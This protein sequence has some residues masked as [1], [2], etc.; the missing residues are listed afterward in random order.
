VFTY[1]LED[2][3]LPLPHP[4]SG[5]CDTRNR[6]TH[7]FQARFGWLN[8]F[9]AELGNA[10]IIFYLFIKLAFPKC[11]AQQVRGKIGGRPP[12]KL[13]MTHIVQELCES[14]GG[15]PGLSVLTSLL[16]SVD[17]KNY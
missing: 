10:K 13:K 7:C 6:T 14:P 12:N 17:V 1:F 4:L 2:R 11:T 3:A 8:M 15:R 9:N 16:V 5:R